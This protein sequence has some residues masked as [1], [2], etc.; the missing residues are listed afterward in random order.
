MKG[1]HNQADLK[2]LDEAVASA[3]R[4]TEGYTPALLHELVK[5]CVVHAAQRPGPL[6]LTREDMDRALT[7][8]GRREPGLR[9]RT[10]SLIR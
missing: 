9:A 8:L 7:D 1:G 4:S 3:A 2:R 6:A 5:K 10:V